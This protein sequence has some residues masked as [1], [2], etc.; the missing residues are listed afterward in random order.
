MNEIKNNLPYHVKATIVASKTKLCVNDDIRKSLDMRQLENRCSKLR[1]S[2]RPES[3][4]NQDLEKNLIKERQTAC[5]FYQGEE[6]RMAQEGYQ[7][8]R[9]NPIIDMIDDRIQK[10]EGS[11]TSDIEDLMK[12]GALYSMCPYYLSKSRVAGSDIVIMPYSYMLNA[13]IR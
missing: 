3:P 1:S 12:E 6:I 7:Q 2:K 5:S 8:K 13:Q 10:V 11:R 4:S 9:F